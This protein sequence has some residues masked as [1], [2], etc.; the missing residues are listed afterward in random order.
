MKKSK[1]V[2]SI[3]LTMMV[4]MASNMLVFADNEIKND[5]RMVTSPAKYEYTTKTVNLNKTSLDKLHTYAY[6]TNKQNSR[7]NIVSLG[8][9]ML[10]LVG[11]PNTS[12]IIGTVANMMQSGLDVVETMNYSYQNYKYLVNNPKVKTVRT[13]IPYRRFFDGNKMHP[14]HPWSYPKRG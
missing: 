14:W 7:A 2:I 11:L 3:V 10:G 9:Y 6:R 4:V 13:K 1:P 12:T 5:E 8:S